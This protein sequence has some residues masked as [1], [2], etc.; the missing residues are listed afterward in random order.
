MNVVI[1]HVKTLKYWKARG[2]WVTDYRK[3]WHFANTTDAMLQFMESPVPYQ[4]VLKYEER[5]YDVVIIK[6]NC[7]DEAS[8]FTTNSLLPKLHVHAAQNK[9]ARSPTRSSL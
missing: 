3:A 5:R 8:D 1:Q 7:S 6:F 9:K 2:A 4:I